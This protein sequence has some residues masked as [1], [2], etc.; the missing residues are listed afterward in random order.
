M[1]TS[2]GM[3]FFFEKGS[4]QK[5]VDNVIIVHMSS[6]AWGKMSGCW[7]PCC[8]QLALQSSLPSSKGSDKV[9]LL[10]VVIGVSREVSLHCRRGLSRLPGLWVPDSYS[11][12]QSVWPECP[13]DLLGPVLASRLHFVSRKYFVGD[14][15]VLIIGWLLPSSDTIFDEVMK[16]WP[17]P[18]DLLGSVLASRVHCGK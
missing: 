7:Q 16:M 10:A 1:P 17:C 18:D 6:P 3:L 5:K 11:R 2:S 4:K 13:E 8:N 12:C 14:M 9:W 15:L